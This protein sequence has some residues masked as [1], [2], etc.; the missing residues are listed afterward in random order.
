MFLLFVTGKH[1]KVDSLK[2]FTKLQQLENIVCKSN[3]KDGK[4]EVDVI[5]SFILF[6]QQQELVNNINHL[7]FHSSQ[8]RFDS[9]RVLYSSRSY[10]IV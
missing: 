1:Q 2:Q 7:F 6:L 9:G 3:L 10:L 8:L 4:T 5:I